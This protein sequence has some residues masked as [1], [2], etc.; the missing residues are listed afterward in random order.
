MSYVGTSAAIEMGDRV[1]TS[2]ISGSQYPGGLFIGTIVDTYSD[3]N[4]GDLIA[5]VQPG[6]DFNDL[7]SVS[8]ALIVCGIEG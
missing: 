8:D 1:Y 4:T 7:E 5:V 6:V 2:G 3:P